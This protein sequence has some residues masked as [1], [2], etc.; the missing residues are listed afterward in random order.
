MTIKGCE[1]EKQK[2]TTE[3]YEEHRSMLRG[4]RQ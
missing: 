4:E 3:N 1:K 2:I